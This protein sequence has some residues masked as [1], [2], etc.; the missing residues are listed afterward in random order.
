MIQSFLRYFRKNTLIGRTKHI[1]NPIEEDQYNSSY[2]NEGKARDE[3]HSINGTQ[4]TQKNEELIQRV[5]VPNTPFE[6]VNRG[7]GWFIGMSPFI[8][9]KEYTSIKEAKHALERD[10]WN[11]IINLLTSIVAL[12]NKDINKGA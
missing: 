6:A 2:S 3:M 12:Q 10:K 7:K 4:P 1:S 9:T 11:I 5:K 8:L